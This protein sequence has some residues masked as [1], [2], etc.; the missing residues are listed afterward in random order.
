MRLIIIFAAM[1]TLSPAFCADVGNISSNVIIKIGLAHR[2]NSAEFEIRGKT[3]FTDE[4]SG[5][6]KSVS[7]KQNIEVKVKNSGLN[8][9]KFSLGSAVRITPLEG[10]DRLKFGGKSYRGGLV[11]RANDDGTVTVI[12]ELDIEEYLCGVLPYEMGPEW[13]LQ[14]LK[15]QAVTARTYVLTENKKF[16]DAG[17]HVSADVRSQMYGGSAYTAP[18]ILTAVRSTAGEV[19]SYK[20]KLVPAFYHAS[21]GGAT[22]SSEVWGGEA[23]RPLSGVPCKYCK[24]IKKFQWT[25]KISAEQILDFLAQ[26]GLNSN[27]LRGLRI[28]KKDKLGRATLL[29]FKTKNGSISAKSGDF[30][31]YA[32]RGGFK[33]VFISRIIHRG[34]DFEIMG[35]GS[36]HGVGLCQE[37]AKQMALNKKDYRRILK[38]YYPGAEITGYALK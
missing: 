33:S 30:C 18:S 15:A 36:G 7:G 16:K 14:A 29:E 5:E 10:E 11:V 2:I 20:G 6:K 3:L 13:P 19:L 21:C 8:F 4:K 12:E 31:R 34:N 24:N 23:V 37:G 32:G 28:S 26:I 35:R 9:G 38:Y 17:F 27:K 25:I 1:F 22:A